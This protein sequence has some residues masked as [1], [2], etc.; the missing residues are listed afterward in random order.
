MPVGKALLFLFLFSPIVFGKGFQFNINLGQDKPETG[1][2]RSA[3]TSLIKFQLSTEPEFFRWTSAFTIIVGGGLTQGDFSVG[4][5]IYPLIKLLK[6]SPAQPYFG[7]EGISGVQV[8]PLHLI[9]AD[10]LH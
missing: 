10:S 6:D 3:N 1:A 7:A 5:A 2:K 9:L 4:T 8:L